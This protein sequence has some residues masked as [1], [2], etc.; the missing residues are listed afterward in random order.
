M[1]IRLARDGRFLG[2]LG[3]ADFDPATKT[4]WGARLALEPTAVKELRE[5]LPRDYPGFAVDASMALGCYLFREVGV[6]VSR[7]YF[8]ASNRLSQR[9]HEAVGMQEIGRGLRT[10]PD[11]SQVETIEMQMT[12]ARWKELYPSG[13][14]PRV[15]AVSMGVRSAREGRGGGRVRPE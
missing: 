10:R 5:Q 4:V 2:T 9:V 6:E 12:R 11:G 15:T 13:Y 3:W 8:F 7:T 1:S 14:P